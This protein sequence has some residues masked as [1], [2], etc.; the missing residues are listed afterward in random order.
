MPIAIRRAW[1]NAVRNS[2][3]TPRRPVH[4]LARGA[5]D[6]SEVELGA[7]L[8]QESYPLAAGAAR[9]RVESRADADRLDET[10]G[11]IAATPST[12]AAPP[13]N[14]GGRS[15]LVAAEAL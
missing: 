7:R 6:H 2:R 5:A 9:G 12:A 3:R 4:L 13:R 8:P 10:A 14:A 11:H 1:S 15:G